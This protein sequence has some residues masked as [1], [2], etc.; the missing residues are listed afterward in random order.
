MASKKGRVAK[1]RPAKHAGVR[2]AKVRPSPDRNAL[3]ALDAAREDVTL[4]IEGERLKLT[5]LDKL[6]WPPD[7]GAGLE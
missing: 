7:E 6:L 3:A 4:E 1:R 5:H 2:K